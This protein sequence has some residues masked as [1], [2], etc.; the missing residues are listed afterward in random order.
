VEFYHTH[1]RTERAVIESQTAQTQLN[2]WSAIKAPVAAQP[3]ALTA[4]VASGMNDVLNSQSYAQAALWNRL[5]AAA[6]AL[7]GLIAI[8]SNFLM[9]FGARSLLSRSVIFLLVLPLVV[10]IALFLIAD[11]DSPRGGVIQ[12]VPQNLQSL[13]QAMG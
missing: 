4:L 9:G 10:S 7:L 2:L 6:W 1:T 12:V 5:P 8:L 13:A 3:T 11:I